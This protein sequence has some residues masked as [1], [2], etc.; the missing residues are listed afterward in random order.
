MKKIATALIIAL[1]FVGC[2]STPTTNIE[3]F[4]SATKKVTDKIDGVIKEY[5]SENIKNELTKLAQRRKPIT[6]SQFAPV[7]DAIIGDADKRKYALYRANYAIGSY[8]ESLAGLAKSGT[9]EEIDLA[10]TKLYYSLR[11]FNEQYKVLKGAENDLVSDETSAGIGKVIAAIGGAYAE[12]KRGE[13]IKTIVIKA[14][15]AIQTICNV[16][17]D[18]LLK[19]VIESRLYTMRNTELSGYIKDYNA[20]VSTASFSDKRASIDKLYDKYIAMQ[21]SSASVIQAI[22]AMKE[23]KSAHSVLKKDMEKNIFTSREIVEAIG[24]LKDLERHYN[25]LEELMLSCETEIISDN[26]RGIICKP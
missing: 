13:A 19:G 12:R 8:A 18:E 22:R 4:G 26:E 6:V 20:S 17:I 14:D 1:I 5:N 10:A 3:A 24:K 15:P 23:V 9:R 7:K 16:I 25:D 21:S 2:A 11:N